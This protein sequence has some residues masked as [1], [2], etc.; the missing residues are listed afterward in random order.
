M[1][2]PEALYV[3]SLGYA[4]GERRAD[5]HTA[6]LAGRLRSDAA[7]LL[8]AGFRWH[9]RC[10]PGTSPY[11]L[12]SAAVG[13]LGETTGVDA[14]V[15]ASC[16]PVNAGGATRPDARGDIKPMLDF[17]AARLQADLGLPGAIVVG[18]DQQACTG[19][20]GSI[21]MAAALLA[22]EP[23]WRQVLCVTA[24]RFPAGAV[25][26]Q[27]YNLISDG[28]AACLVGRRPSA[29]RLRTVHQI[30][31]G[32]LGR[33]GDDETVGMYFGYTHRL[34][35]ET[36]A[37]IGLT[38]ADLDWVVTQNTHPSAWQILS[39]LLEIDPAKV[40]APSLPEVG[41]VI[42]ADVVVNLSELIESGRLRAGELVALVMAGYGLTWQC[43]VLEVVA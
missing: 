8:D 39:R 42:S 37:R 24:D 35:R 22:T 2:L 20:L 13:R 6:A 28:A 18:I 31:N 1:D 11:Q 17:P 38:P 26:E 5:V 41:H 43:A 32:G 10:A 9:H 23:E 29:L 12:A 30:T 34:V 40:W 25:Y 15:Y 19:M 21:R 27:A 7:D 16:L 14:I 3:G 36:L 33:A 4:L